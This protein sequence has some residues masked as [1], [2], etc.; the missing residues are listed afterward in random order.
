MLPGPTMSVRGDIRVGT[1]ECLRNARATSE[2][3]NQRIRPM[4]SYGPAFTSRG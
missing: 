1:L 4:Y 3:K 2:R